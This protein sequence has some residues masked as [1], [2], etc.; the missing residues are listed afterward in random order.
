[1]DSSLLPRLDLE[2]PRGGSQ[3][4]QAAPEDGG[5]G[6]LAGILVRV[7]AHFGEPTDDVLHRRF[8]GGDLRTKLEHLQGADLERSELEAG[9]CFWLG[10][11]ELLEPPESNGVGRQDRRPAS[12]GVER[13]ELR[14]LDITLAPLSPATELLHTPALSV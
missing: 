13:A 3:V 5:T 8:G 4:A 11:R 2:K 7:A 6:R 12:Q 14:R 10:T 1:M 9:G